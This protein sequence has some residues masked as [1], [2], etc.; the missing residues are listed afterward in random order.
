MR[1]LLNLFNNDPEFYYQERESQKS[2]LENTTRRHYVNGF[3][4]HEYDNFAR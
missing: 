1:L 2:E 4:K 3:S